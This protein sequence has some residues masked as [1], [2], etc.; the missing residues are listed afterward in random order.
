MIRKIGV[1]AALLA[2]GVAVAWYLTGGFA[3]RGGLAGFQP[4]TDASA[5]VRIAHLERALAVQVQRAGTL[6]ARIAGLE[7]RLGASAGAPGAAV[8]VEGV[9][10]EGQPAMRA[11]AGENDRPDPATMRARMR[12]RGLER[13]VVA[14]FSR[15]RAEWIHRRTEELQVQVMQAQY[16]AQRS[17]RPG[18]AQA[19]VQ[20]SLR[21]EMGDVEYERYLAATGRPTEVQVT[22]VLASS[23]A[24]RAGLQAGDQILSYDGKRVFDMRELN[25]LTREGTPGEPVTMEVKRHGQ[26]LQVTVPRGVLGTTARGMRQ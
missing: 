25:R 17:G 24:E 6:E 5:E 13:L 9:P 1:V 19:D 15:E 16:D 26:T 23:P 21:A 22:G 12:E 20:Q 4:D 8:G 18:Q 2:F 14:G 10:A 3:P 11:P 7:S